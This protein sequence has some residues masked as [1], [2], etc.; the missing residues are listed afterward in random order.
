[1]VKLNELFP[2]TNLVNC[3]FAFR[4]NNTTISTIV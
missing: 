2:A 3:V 4:Q 1:M